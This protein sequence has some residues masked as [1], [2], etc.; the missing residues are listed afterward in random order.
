MEDLKRQQLFDKNEKLIRMVIERAKR[1]FPEDI[2]IIGVTGSFRTGDFHEKSDLDLIIINNTDR[3]WGISHCFI[4]EDVGYDLY[5]T[6]WNTRIEDQA[7]LESPMVSCLVDLQIVYYA[8]PED[9]EKFQSYRQR[10]LDALAQPFGSAWIRRAKKH[11]DQAKQEYA[12]TWLADDLGA[13]RYASCEVVYHLMNALTQL[14]HTY[15]KR[16]MKRY[17]EETRT[18]RHLPANYENNYMAVIN[19]KT[20]DDIRSTTCQLLKSMQHLYERLDRECG[21]RPVPTWDNLSGTYEELWCNYRNKMIASTEMKD[22]SYAFHA[23]MGAQGFLNEMNQMLGTPAFDLMAY[24]DADHLDR[25]KERF[26]QVME[27]YLEE[28]HKVGKPVNR[29]DTFEQLYEHYM[30]LSKG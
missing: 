21:E 4:L 13:V 28:Y 19:A 7:N 24:F 11:L 5:C 20:V 30:N 23:A 15:I 22:K 2:A 26:L 16:G 18:Y 14:N 29:Y 1:D 27:E 17:L 6:P 8:K 12:Q 25:V 10:A 9:L 3:G